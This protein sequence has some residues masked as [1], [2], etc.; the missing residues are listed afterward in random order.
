[1][2]E[3]D[4]SA[5]EDTREEG[6]GSPAPDMNE[7]TDELAALWGLM[8]QLLTGSASLP[9][10]GGSGDTAYHQANINAAF[11][12]ITTPA[13]AILPLMPSGDT[14][15]ATDT[16]AIK[17]QLADYSYC[18]LGPGSFYISPGEI[19]VGPAQALRGHG[20]GQ[21][22]LYAVGGT[23]AQATL[24]FRNE[25]FPT[26]G[27]PFE[28]AN[29]MGWNGGFVVDGSYG[30]GAPAG[31]N[32]IELGDVYA[33]NLF[34]VVVREFNG[35]GSKGIRV[36]NT[37]GWTERVWVVAH[38]SHCNTAV[39]WEH[40]DAGGGQSTT[41]MAYSHWWVTVHQNAGQNGFS[42]LNGC[43]VYGGSVWFGGNFNSAEDSNT[44][45]A[46]MIGH[47]GNGGNI[48]SAAGSI[49]FET[50]GSSGGSYVQAT[51]MYIGTSASLRLAGNLIF[52]GGNAWVAGT[53][54]RTQVTCNGFQQTAT[55]GNGSLYPKKAANTSVAVGT[56]ANTPGATTTISPDGAFEQLIPT[57]FS[58][59]I[60]GIG[61]E[62]VTITVVSNFADGT[63]ETNTDTSTTDQTKVWAASSIGNM[64]KATNPINSFSL[65][66]QS[67]IS[68]SA[69]TVTC[70]LVA[71]N[72]L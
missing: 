57:M 4:L 72:Q 43:S 32:G 45:I 60:A 14:S 17:T 31:V 44:S 12:A 41:S 47:D 38:V 7:T 23:S 28:P 50:D 53:A 16:A 20:A 65:T 1:M 18:Y 59:T 19:T 27:D 49:S 5:I 13:R 29:L 11:A 48:Q 69:A 61:S 54:S 58:W 68:G 9:V 66:A 63:T 56:T 46:L 55:L 52:R 21:T 35:S 67:T 2:S 70:T 6:E 64:M 71:L 8:S 40:N 39:T 22:I 42:V 10:N 37:I 30:S 34:N 25:S 24:T 3:P 26:S 51:D 33:M 62:T 15:G 36:N